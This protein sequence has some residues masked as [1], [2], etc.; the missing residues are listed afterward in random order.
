MMTSKGFKRIFLVGMSMSMLIPQVGYS[1]GESQIS[2]V[3]NQETPVS[4]LKPGWANFFLHQSS[5]KS[6]Y[7]TRGYS[8]AWVDSS[9]SPNSAAK[10]LR[11]ALKN[12]FKQGLNPEDYWDETMETMYT[13]GN[14]QSAWITFELAASEAVIRYASHLSNGRF[15]PKDIDNDIKFTQRKF[16]KYS[17]L[18]SVIGSGNI[19]DSLNKTFAPK[20]PQ[21]TNL[22]SLL[23]ELYAR[24][25]MG[26]WS[27]IQNTKFT[28]GA[29]SPAI[30][31]IRTRLKE[32]G[33]DVAQGNTTY[34][35]ELVEA[36][37]KF[38]E[39][40]TMS[41]DGVIGT[42]VLNSLNK[43]PSEL[44]QQVEVNLEKLRWLPEQLEAR[45][46]FV[47]LATTNFV[48][49]DNGQK[50]YDFKTINGQVFRRTPSMRDVMHYVE[51]N[52]TW[53][54]PHS[55][56]TKDKLNKIKA[57]PGYVSRSKMKLHDSAT[58]REVDPYSVNWA[59]VSKQNFGYYLVQQPGYRN[60]LGV[61]KFPLTNGWAIYLHGTD[62]YTLFDRG[63]RLISS[64][65]IRLENPLEFA[66]YIL[67]DNIKIANLKY[68]NNRDPN[69]PL[70]KIQSVVPKKDG[71]EPDPNHLRRRIEMEKPVPVYTLYLTAVKDDSG[72]VQ[73]V[74]D[75]YGQDYRVWQ[76]IKDNRK[77]K[78]L[79]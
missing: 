9:G 38:Q 40:N 52:P 64:G 5:L 70:S 1:F 19:E 51:L 73:F 37:K 4:L 72:R 15:E 58:D 44:I 59:N 33:Y 76:A 71:D 28:K 63:N 12:A 2:A 39:A 6:F 8:A 24:K 65:C 7:E 62:D 74:E 22:I 48:L 41:V 66:D 77:G 53:T 11:T 47:N 18:N 3:T 36:I 69:W 27:K 67:K 42:E 45:H 13:A 30:A 55:I 21:Y 46:A 26:G 78:E 61:V 23:D 32:L 35:S 50:A 57:D 49:M 75:L 54:V 56:A 14:I 34:D 60:A 17:V 10:S 31:Q 29:S 79:F 20:H 25:T 68:G 16:T 43:T